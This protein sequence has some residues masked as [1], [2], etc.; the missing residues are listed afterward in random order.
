MEITDEPHT[1]VIKSELEFS[2]CERQFM[3]W[4]ATKLRWRIPFLPPPFLNSVHK[5]NLFLHKSFETKSCQI[6]VQQ[7][8]ADF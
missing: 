6:Q 7:Y 4:F 5:S 8:D 1:V 2:I 3:T